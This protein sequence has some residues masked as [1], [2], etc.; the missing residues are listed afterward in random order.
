MGSSWGIIAAWLMAGV[1]GGIV[2]SQVARRRGRE[3]TLDI[4]V[5]LVASVVGGLI[6]RQTG[7]AGA[8]AVIAAV[9]AGALAVAALHALRTPPRR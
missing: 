4:A 3:L 1:I 9:L 6:A 8:W 2:A 5:G 7:N